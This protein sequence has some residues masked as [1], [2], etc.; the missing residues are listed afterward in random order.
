MSTPF[1]GKR[2]YF[3]GIG[4]I[5]FEGRQS[6]NPLAF[7]HYDASKKIGDK[8]MAE[9]L[10]FAVCY[11]HSFCNAGHDPFGPGTRHYPWDA[12][13]APIARA[14]AKVD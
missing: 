11:W 10:R 14:E 7:K 4:R 6:D 1:I 8:T 13:A 12:D 3:P 9:H 2:E 5:P